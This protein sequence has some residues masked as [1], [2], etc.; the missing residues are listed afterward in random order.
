MVSAQALPCT[1]LTRSWCSFKAW[2]LEKSDIVPFHGIAA[3]ETQASFLQTVW[4]IIQ[5]ETRPINSS[6]AVLLAA[7]FL[8]CVNDCGNSQLKPPS[9]SSKGG[10]GKLPLCA[11]MEERCWWYH[12]LRSSWQQAVELV[13]IVA[14]IEA[15]A[16]CVSVLFHLVSWFHAGGKGTGSQ[17]GCLCLIERTILLVYCSQTKAAVKQQTRL[18]ESRTAE[19]KHAI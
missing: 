6:K 17:F 1:E 11:G 15:T 12:S 4:I 19:S 5:T 9:I 13:S 10:E 8:L 3:R 16:C 14:S 7:P 2:P 18:S